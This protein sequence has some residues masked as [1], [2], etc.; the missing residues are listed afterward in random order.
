L[1]RFAYPPF[2]TVWQWVGLFPD[3]VAPGPAQLWVFADENADTINDG[4]L[5]TALP[6][7][8]QWDD[9]PGSFH[10]GACVF[11]FADGQTETHKWLSP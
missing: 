1:G 2:G 3:I 6:N 4:W 8:N 11:N 7:P 10:N 9:M 5:I